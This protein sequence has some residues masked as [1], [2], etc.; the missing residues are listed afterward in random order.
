MRVN[1][2]FL[3]AMG[4]TKYDGTLKHGGSSVIVQVV[5]AATAIMNKELY[6]KI[7]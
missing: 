5:F 7:F 4:G 3:S 6:L 2:T 1:L